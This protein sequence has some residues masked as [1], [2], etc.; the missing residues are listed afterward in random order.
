MR[1]ET[2]TWGLHR[3]W[4][5]QENTPSESTCQLQMERLQYVPLPSPVWMVP[6]DCLKITVF[7]LVPNS[8]LTMKK[9]LELQFYNGHV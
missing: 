6:C 4:S 2:S 9:V 8:F 5:L 3:R 7:Y 1:L